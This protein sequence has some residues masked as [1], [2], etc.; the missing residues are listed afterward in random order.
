MDGSPLDQLLDNAVANGAAPGF[1]ATVTSPDGT[2]YEHATPG[3]PAGLDT[4]FRIASMTKALT[5]EAAMQLVERGELELE[6]PVESVIPEFAERHVL[7]GFDG[8]TPQLRPPSRPVLLRHLLTH[9]SG[10]AYGFGSEELLRWES[11]TGHPNLL[12]GK[13]ECIDVPLLFD[14]GERWEYGVGTDWVGRVVERVTGQTLGDYL[15]ANVFDPLGMPDTGFEPTDEQRSRGMDVRFRLPDGG[16]GD[17]PVDLPETMEF[18]SGG[19]GALSTIRDYGRF[20]R[21][22]LRGGEL[23]G[24]RILKAETVDLMLTDHLQGAPLPEI[25]K[26]AIPELT[27]DVPALPFKQGWGLGFALVLEDIPGMRRAGTGNWAGLFNCYFWI[28]RKSGVAG[29]LMTQLLPFFDLRVV[30]TLL[31]FEMG[32]YAQLGAAAP[33]TA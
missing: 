23:D 24:E 18:H 5:S 21:A 29:A 25:M 10:L 2:L 6:Q 22:M 11:V 17:P 14:P 31:G 26:S 7:E 13:S 3:L 20:L 27:N 19:G 28:D 9:T 4:V 32:V 15:R 12:T 33:A 30:E 8:D 16:L 1:A